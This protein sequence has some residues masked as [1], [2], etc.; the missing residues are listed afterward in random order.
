MKINIPQTQA[1][2]YRICSILT[3]RKPIRPK[4]VYRVPSSSSRS[5][6]FTAG[7]TFLKSSQIS[8]KSSHGSTR[9]GIPEKHGAKVLSSLD[10]K[11][12]NRNDADLRD[13]MAMSD[14]ILLGSFPPPEYEVEAVLARCDNIANNLLSPLAKQL[15]DKKRSAAIALLSVNEPVAAKPAPKPQKFS[16]DT[17]NYFNQLS[18]VAYSIL[19]HPPVF[20]TPNILERY[21]NLHARLQ[22]PE[23]FPEIFEL[24][25]TKA[26]PV[27]GTSPTRY[28]QQW[29]DKIA[30]AIKS[31]VADRALQTAIDTKQLT[32][33]MDIIESTYAKKAFRRDKFARKALLPITGFALAPFAIYAVASKFAIY[34]VSMDP[35]MATNMAFAGILAYVGFTS[36][37]GLVAIATANDQMD[38]VTWVQGMPLRQR[39]IREE[40]RAAIDKVAGAWGFREIWRRGEE[41][42]EEWDALREWIGRKGMIL[43]RV[44]LMEGME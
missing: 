1:S 4:Q 8:V 13:V 16:L 40:E 24:Y 28:R 12:Q 25:S 30:N 19:L 35:T 11:R 7:H 32:V 10:V 22:K 44:E 20:I 36:T 39:W 23:T 27:E 43:D 6:N 15:E 29:P 5:R 33:A 31:A 38:R 2:G 21:V 3:V 14:K 34:Q 26:I 42:G 41:E 37:I 18:K 9:Q 17:Q